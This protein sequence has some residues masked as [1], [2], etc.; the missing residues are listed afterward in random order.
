MSYSRYSNFIKD[1]KIEIVPFIPIPK[2]N[3]DYYVY[4]K[5]NETRL[6]I[7]S[8]DYYGDSNYDWLIMQA[9][10]QYSPLEFNI[11]DGAL[12][13]IPYPLDAVIIQYNNDIKKYK[14]LYGTNK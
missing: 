8:Y 9:N 13:R 3:S 10:P 2:R 11:M 1:G 4:Y 7:L 5:A 12:L 14:E 6:D